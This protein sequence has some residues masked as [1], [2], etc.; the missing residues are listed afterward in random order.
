MNIWPQILNCN[1]IAINEKQ[2]RLRLL[3]PDPQ[4]NKLGKD[5]MVKDLKRILVKKISS[6]LL[7]QGQNK[8][9]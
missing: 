2:N 7:N 4:K 9:T 1:P 5:R 6:Y 3:C 8:F